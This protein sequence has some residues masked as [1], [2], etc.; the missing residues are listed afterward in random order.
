M[1]CEEIFIGLLA[2]IVHGSLAEAGASPKP[3]SHHQL[4]I[5]SIKTKLFWADATIFQALV[6]AYN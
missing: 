3:L 5:C 6:I 1:L 4:G 2:S